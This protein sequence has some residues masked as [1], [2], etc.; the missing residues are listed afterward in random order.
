MSFDKEY[1]VLTRSNNIYKVS[2]FPNQDKRNILAS[3]RAVEGEGL[4]VR[5][6]EETRWIGLE[7][8][9]CENTVKTG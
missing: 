1:E 6:R 5:K 7:R 8:C 9:K 2:W 3:L 4:E